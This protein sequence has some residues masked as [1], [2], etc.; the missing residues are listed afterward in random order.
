MARSLPPLP[1][2]QNSKEKWLPAIIAGSHFL[3]QVQT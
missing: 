1:Y 2:N 3:Y